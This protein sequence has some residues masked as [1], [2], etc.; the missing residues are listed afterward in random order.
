MTDT[1]REALKHF[2]ASNVRPPSVPAMMG[3]MHTWSSTRSHVSMPEVAQP[4]QYA[5]DHQLVGDKRSGQVNDWREIF[6]GASELLLCNI[7]QQPHTEAP[8]SNYLQGCSE[9]R[10]KT[11]RA[12]SA[13]KRATKPDP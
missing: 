3:W 13:N 12:C 7:L 4:S 1:D 10:G 2:Y 9:T 5:A 6:T 8:W 11:A